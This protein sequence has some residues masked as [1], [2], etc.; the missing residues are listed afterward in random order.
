[1]EQEG[2]SRCVY[3]IFT[4]ANKLYAYSIYYPIPFLL[5]L[6]LLHIYSFPWFL[7]P[8]PPVLISPPYLFLPLISHSPSSCSYL[9]SIFIP[10]PDFSFPFLLFLSLIHIYSFLWF[11]IPLS[12]SPSSPL[13]LFPLFYYSPFPIPFHTK[14]YEFD[15]FSAIDEVYLGGKVC[16]WPVACVWF[17]HYVNNYICLNN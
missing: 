7:I 15:S 16:Q 4:I 17:F 11:L 8:L 14:T 13:P 1:M 12:S 5:F 2:I 9:S 3:I 10:S 6:S